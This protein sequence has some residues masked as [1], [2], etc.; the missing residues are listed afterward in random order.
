M[1]IFLP[2]FLQS[3]AGGAGGSRVAVA[4]LCAFGTYPDIS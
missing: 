4:P 1:P 3:F 2:E